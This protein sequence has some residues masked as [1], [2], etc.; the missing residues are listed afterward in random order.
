M[1]RLKEQRLWDVFSAAAEKTLKLHRVENLIGNGMPDVIGIND[2]GTSFW[3]ELKA[4]DKWPVRGT[5]A[6]LR[7]AFEPGQIGFQKEWNSWNG[8]AFTLLRIGVS[9]FM[10]LSASEHNLLTLTQG[11]ILDGVLCHGKHEIV[12]Y[13]E[14]L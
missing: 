10:L 4:I 6:V 11:Q 5:T 1:A 9:E 14:K 8:R 2:R 12:K 3:I 7:N 13:L